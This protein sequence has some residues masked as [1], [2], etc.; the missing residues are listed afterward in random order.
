MYGDPGYTGQEVGVTP[1]GFARNFTPE[2]LRRRTPPTP[3]R[4]R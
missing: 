1:Y 4:S 2:L 3:A